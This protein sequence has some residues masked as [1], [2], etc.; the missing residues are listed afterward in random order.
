[1]GKTSYNGDLFFLEPRE[2]RNRR[3]AIILE[4]QLVNLKRQIPKSAA[5]ATG[6][7]G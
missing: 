1:M 2:N 7:F 3:S 6:A 4:K 5:A